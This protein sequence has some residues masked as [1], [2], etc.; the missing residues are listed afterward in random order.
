M[1]KIV[2]QSVHFQCKV[3]WR[4]WVLAVTA[5]SFVLTHASLV[6]GAE[7]SVNPKRLEKLAS[8]LESN[9]WQVETATLKELSQSL[10]DYRRA[11]V[12]L[13]PIIE[14]LFGL[15]G[16]GG[17]AR[18]NSWTAES[19]LVWIGRPVIP[20]LQRRLKSDDAHDRRVAIELLAR[21]GP[22]DA[23]LVELLR[24]FLTDP[25]RF[26][27]RAAINGLGEIGVPAKSAIRDLERLAGNDP[28]LILRIEA[29]SALIQVAGISDKRILNLAAFLNLEQTEDVRTACSHAASQ[30]GR[31]GPKAKVA[32]PMLLTTLKHPHAQVRIDV[33]SALGKVGANSPETI[34]ALIDSL[35]H[36]LEREVRRSAAGS[37]G[38]IGP[39]A[40]AAIPA[41]RKALAGDSQGGWRVALDALYKIDSPDIVAILTESL[42]NPD[43]SIR[44]VAVERLG[45]LGVRAKPAIAALEKCSQQDQHK[46]IR[47]AA[48]DAIQ[49]IEQQ[50]RPEQAGIPKQ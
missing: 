36:D 1:E 27:R 33:A 2:K 13:T 8:Q 40:K 28:D 29:H 38:A 16:G 31:L 48:A 11:N 21:I 37:L 25:G 32:E 47:A 23:S 3:T 44:Q 43:D 24:P 26:V 6:V 10:P 4:C 7:E 14:P 22:R 42:S 15:A 5:M 45:E 18:R 35:S 17:I 41:L 12:D 50:L 39:Q 9:D 46:Y 30:L 49:K 19:M 34:S 20:L